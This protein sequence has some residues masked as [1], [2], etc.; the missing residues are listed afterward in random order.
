MI[1]SIWKN[2]EGRTVIGN[3]TALL[4]IQGANVILPLITLPYLV[5]TLGSEKFGLVMIAQS[6]GVLLTVIVDFGFNISATREVSLLRK[7]KIKLSQFYWNVFFVKIFLLVIALGIILFLTTFIER[8][9]IEA[10]VYVLSFGMVIGQAIFPTWFFQGIEKM[11]VI[12][13]V[14]ILAKT[15]F[16]VSIFIFVLKP[17]DY[18]WV[19]ICN[20][21]GFI[22]AGII[23]LIYSLKYI[24]F[25]KPRLKEAFS[26]T[27]ESSALFVSNFAT[28]L[29]TSSNTFILGMVGGD[30][31]AGVYSSMEKLVLAIKNV[32]V[33]LYQAIFP[34][35]TTKNIDRIRGFVKKMI[36]PVTISGLLIALGIII[37]AKPLLHFI[38]DNSLIESYSTIFQI[39]ALI[40]VFSSVNMLFVSLYFPSVKQYK[41]RMKILIAGGLFNLSVALVVAHLYGIYGVAISAVSTELFILILATY[42]FKKTPPKP[43]EEI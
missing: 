21:G 15:L 10:W 40:A 28:N 43:K 2:K 12:T 5:R 24:N 34:W 42:F 33:P 38:Y 18:L 13:V 30:A 39:L 26:I 36:I 6:L 11:R 20:G 23:G 27:K 3:Y 1:K 19:P 17:S 29:Y 16:T 4:F 41:T 31:I 25:K 22:L 14:N 7:D 9:K 32:Y 8:F 35:L 37:L